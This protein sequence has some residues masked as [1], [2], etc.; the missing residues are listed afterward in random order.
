MERDDIR[1]GAARSL[2][3]ENTGC[4]LT[5]MAIR[6]SDEVKTQVLEYA[7]Q[8]GPPAAAKKFNVSESAIYLWKKPG[9][10]EKVKKD[11]EERIKHHA[12]LIP[13]TP[14]PKPKS[15]IAVIICDDPS[16]VAEILKGMKD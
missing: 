10:G 1:L 6:Y 13:D 7:K 9:H 4:G 5:H 3:D 8:H 2:F 16:S 14:S 12:M 15:K 11:R